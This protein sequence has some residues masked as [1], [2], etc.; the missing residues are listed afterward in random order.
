[1]THAAFSFE[2][3]FTADGA[4]LSGPARTYVSRVEV[5]QIAAAARAEGEA[6]ARA[7]A[8]ANVERIVGQMAP[9]A[10][11]IAGIADALRREAAELA[12][13][14]ARKI[15]GDALDAR[16][17]EAAANGVA[18]AVR[19]LKNA[20]VIHVCAAPAAL[21]EI[22]QKLEQL[23][24]QR[25]AF[26]VDFAADPSAKPGDWRVEW[27]EGVV[28]FSRDDVEAAIAAAIAARLDDPVEFQLE[29]FSA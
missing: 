9:V 2:T 28:A 10:A 20:P 4:V 24:Q 5:D 23:R 19:L 27:G 22:A 12:L 7:V 15:A 14:A 18:E 3:E 17:I 16:G 26:A 25:G 11:Q 1:M 8:A 29:L 13:M 6:R 21:P